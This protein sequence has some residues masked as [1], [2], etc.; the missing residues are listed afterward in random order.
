MSVHD[1]TLQGLSEI[2]EY[3]KG[4]KTK[5]RSVTVVL[6]DDEAEM[7]FCQKFKNLSDANKHRAIGYIDGLLQASGR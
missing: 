6:P 1:D 4:D 2:L 5:A 3:V 7:L